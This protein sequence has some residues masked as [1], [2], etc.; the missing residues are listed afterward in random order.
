MRGHSDFFEGK[1]RKPTW[2]KNVIVVFHRFYKAVSD[3]AKP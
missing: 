1:H 2:K 3:T